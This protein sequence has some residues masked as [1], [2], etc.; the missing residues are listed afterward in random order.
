MEFS[1]EE[2]IGSIYLFNLN[3]TRSNLGGSRDSERLGF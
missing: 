2:S 3:M 1:L